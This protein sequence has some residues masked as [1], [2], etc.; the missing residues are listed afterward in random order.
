MGFEVELVNATMVLEELGVACKPGTDTRGGMVLG[1]LV[2]CAGK[3][4]TI[5]H[6]ISSKEANQDH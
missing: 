2:F 4:K 6:A 1:V 3:N 5:S